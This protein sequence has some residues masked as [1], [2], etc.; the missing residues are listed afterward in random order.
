[1]KHSLKINTGESGKEGVLAFM[2]DISIADA[3]DVK[4]IIQGALKQVEQLNLDLEGVETADISFLQLLCASH[5]DVDST[6]KKIVLNR[7]MSGEI[8]GKLARIGLAKQT[9]CS[10][11]LVS[12]CLWFSCKN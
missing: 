9:G 7:E 8:V 12:S 5:R 3:R 10:P 11:G 2:G 4:G 6:S 1:M